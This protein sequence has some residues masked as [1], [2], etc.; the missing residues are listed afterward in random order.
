ML[1]LIVLCVVA[2]MTRNQH[3]AGELRVHELP[4]T[5]LAAMNPSESG[6]FQLGDQLANLARHTPET[7]IGGAPP[8]AS[9]YA[10]VRAWRSGTEPNFGRRAAN[11]RCCWP[12][13]PRIATLPRTAS[14]D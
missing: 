10:A 6:S 9:I 4:V 7:A 3:E 1:L 14:T 12:R 13:E 2:V 11:V 8:P 5:A